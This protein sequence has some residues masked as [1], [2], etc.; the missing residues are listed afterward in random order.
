MRSTCRD[1]TAG[2]WA[3]N[4]RLTVRAATG[5]VLDDSARTHTHTRTT[6][7]HARTHART[8]TAHARTHARAHKHAP[9]AQARQK[10]PEQTGA[11][12]ETIASDGISPLLVWWTFCKFLSGRWT[13][14]E[15]V[16]VEHLSFGVARARTG[17]RT[18]LPLVSTRRS[19]CPATCDGCCFSSMSRSRNGSDFTEALERAHMHNRPSR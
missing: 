6:T 14:R 13:N 17:L 9:G 1:E 2:D 10:T 18:R 7:A 8:T 12:S 19:P 5:S 3:A 15:P 11:A 4:T 16:S